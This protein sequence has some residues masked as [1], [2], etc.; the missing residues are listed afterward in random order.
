VALNAANEVAVA[1]FLEKKIRFTDIAAVVAGAL[2][3]H[4]AGPAETVDAI[5]DIDR[6]ARRDARRHFPQR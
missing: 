5:I 4:R 3:K 1:A 6:N 2:D